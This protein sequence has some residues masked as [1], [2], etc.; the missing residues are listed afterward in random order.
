MFQPFEFCLGLVP[1]P[2]PIVNLGKQLT[3]RNPVGI[4]SFEPFERRD[5][6]RNAALF[7]R[8]NRLLQLRFQLAA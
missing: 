5:R 1:L 2:G 6:F 7:R 4:I 8:A 3:R